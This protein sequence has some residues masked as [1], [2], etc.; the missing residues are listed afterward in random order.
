MCTVKMKEGKKAKKKK[1]K[2]TTTSWEKQCQLLHNIYAC[3]YNVT[4]S[5]AM[6]CFPKYNIE[7]RGSAT[8]E[9]K[10]QIFYTPT[11]QETKK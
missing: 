4:K 11:K 9:P 5:K 6:L 3:N 8:K 10:N 7:K 1:G 2:T